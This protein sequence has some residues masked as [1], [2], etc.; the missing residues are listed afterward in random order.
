MAYVTEYL[1]G[2][3]S[4]VN[5]TTGATVGV[6]WDLQQPEGIAIAP[7]GRLI[8]AEVGAQRLIAIDP[9]TGEVETVA[10]GLPIGLAGGD[11]LP[12]PFLLTGVAVEANGSIIF[13]SDIENAIYRVNPQ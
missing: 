5:L 12:P 1:S 7:D 8:V 3:V 13:S 10:D 9:G 11:D 2:V 4:R 6:A